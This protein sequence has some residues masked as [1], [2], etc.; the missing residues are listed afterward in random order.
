MQRQW[1]KNEPTKALSFRDYFRL[2]IKEPYRFFFPLGIFWGIIGTLL[3][4]LSTFGWMPSVPALSHPR[5]M[6]EGFVGSFVIGFLCTSLPRLLEVPPLSFILLFLIGLFLFVSNSFHFF[7]FFAAGDL[8]FG[9]SLLLFLFA[10]VSRFPF[11]KDNP[12]PS[13]SFP[14]F[15]VAGATLG[16]F[17]QAIEE[18][19]RSIGLFLHHFSLLLL[20]QGLP[21]F[22]ILGVSAYFLPRVF[23]KESPEIFP[24]SLQFSKQ[25]IKRAF[26]ATTAA[27]FLLLSFIFE[28]AGLFFAGGILR[29]CTII[30]YLLIAFPTKINLLK[31]GTV[32]R[33]FRL[34]LLFSVL[35]FILSSFFLLKRADWLHLFFLGGGGLMIIMVGSRVVFGFS[36]RTSFLSSYFYP[37]DIV[38]LGV[39][40]SLLLR[41]TADFFATL[42]PIVISFAATLWIVVLIYWGLTALPLVFFPDTED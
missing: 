38:T 8:S 41:L 11:R 1:L 26:L 27:F 10:F 9:F 2:G 37:L 28:A 5:I 17:L 33:G 20:F 40:L 3:W 36:G 22:P 6:I 21:L 12:P 39:L 24:T 4:P 14:F 18:S 30:G 23:D 32:P 15:G 29:A 13:F 25:W 16:T 7:G 31:R 34:A 19:G 42:R 35:G